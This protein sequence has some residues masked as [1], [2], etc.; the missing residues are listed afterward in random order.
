MHGYWWTDE[1]L[2]CGASVYGEEDV[3]ISQLVTHK[4]HVIEI[5][6]WKAENDTWT[7]GGIKIRVMQHSFVGGYNINL[8]G[9][10]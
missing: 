9:V 1:I 8:G 4:G 7:C 5:I 2:W 10:R 6:T 3:V